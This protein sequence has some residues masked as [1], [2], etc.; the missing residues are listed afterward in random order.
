MPRSKHLPIFAIC[1]GGCFYPGP[2]LQRKG[3]S[4]WCGTIRH[5]G[6]P[7]F[8]SLSISPFFLLLYLSL[9]VS[10]PLGRIFFLIVF[11]S[12]F[13][14]RFSLISSLPESISLSSLRN[15]HCWNFLFVSAD[16]ALYLSLRPISSF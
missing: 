8:F 4:T 6:I 11:C 14:I 5:S 16:S 9:S 3:C 10:S 2:R 15:S 1:L 7:G 12:F 13:S